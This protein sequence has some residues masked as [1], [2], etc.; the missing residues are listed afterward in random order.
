MRWFGYI[1]S[2]L[3]AST[4]VAQSELLTS[5]AEP[6]DAAFIAKLKIDTL[7]PISVQHNQT[8]KTLDSYSRQ[9]LTTITGKK[10]YNG[11]PAVYTVLDMTFRPER[12]REVNIIKIR[13]AVLRQDLMQLKSID[14]NEKKRIGKDGTISLRFW[15]SDEVQH[16]MSNLQSQA[17]FKAQAIGQVQEAAQT[18]ISLS[19][20]DLHAYHVFPPATNAA[21]DHAWHCMP[22]LLGTIPQLVE[23]AKADGLPIP[24]ALPGY[25]GRQTAILNSMVALN[26]LRDAWRTGNV[27]VANK[28][29]E[30]LASSLPLIGPD[31]Y[32]SMAKR[33][34]EVAY[35]RMAQLMIPGIMLYS[36][37]MLL[38]LLSARSG[39]ASLRVWGLRVIVVAFLVHTAG[40][41]IRWWLVENPSATGLSRSPS[42]TSSKA[43]C[44]VCGSPR[45]SR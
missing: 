43:S 29:I 20:P 28:A 23:I 12:Y 11:Q 35:N 32:P 30:T 21:S 22:D 45:S 41:G 44:S 14:D 1:L 37:A 39:M 4:A 8:L 27:D 6:D 31:S 25:E 2:I 7:K 33:Q 9:T 34:M 13:N 10:S 26:H 16:L 15:F 18:L 40:I 36:V 5:V 17:V 3:F 19:Q 42:R 38:F 24:P